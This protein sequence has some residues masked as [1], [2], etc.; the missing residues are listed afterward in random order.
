MNIYIDESG[1]MTHNTKV[2]KYKYFIV[3]LVLVE[4]PEKLKKVYKRFV[5]KYFNELKSIDEKNRMFKG[6]KFVELKGSAFTP[7]MKNKFVDY[8]CKNNHFKILYIRVD[9]SKTYENFYKNKARAFNYVLKLAL[10]HLN[11]E[12]ILIDKTWTIQIDER[13]VR[14]Y[15]RHQLEEYLNT[16]LSTGKNLVDEVFVNYFDSSNNQLVQ[17]ADV[18][19]NLFYSYILTDGAYEDEIQYMIDNGYLIETF[20]FPPNN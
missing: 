16:E 10:K 1:S 5:K 14:T 2:K 19:S 6:G 13:N 15:N 17:L 11:N 20:E 7:E 4:E 3:A 8:F 9:N 18:F 12:K